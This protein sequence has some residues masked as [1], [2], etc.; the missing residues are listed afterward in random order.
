MPYV[1]VV[2]DISSDKVRIA[3]CDKL[4]SMGFSML[5]RSV[6][7]T[8]GGFSNAKDVARAIQRYIDAS[9]D[10]VLVV[11]VSREVLERAIVI[12]VNRL[13]IDERGY[14]VI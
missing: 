7:I 10:S 11:V 4:K 5:Q 6:Y 13:I 2:Y 8:R 12:G 1:I 9:R 14:A 3:V